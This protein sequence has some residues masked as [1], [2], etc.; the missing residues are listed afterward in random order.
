MNHYFNL[1]ILFFAFSFRLEAQK[2]P[3]ELN[4]TGKEIQSVL[5][6]EILSNANK[7]LNELPLTVTAYYAK[8]SAGNRHDFF[9]EGDYWWPDSTNLQG[10]YIQKD[11][12]TNPDNF[13][14][15]RLALI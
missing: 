12:Q 4:E 14:A 15:H 3:I 10:P 2:L 6:K 5:F 9:S 7:A 8:R 1:S 11:G 13:T